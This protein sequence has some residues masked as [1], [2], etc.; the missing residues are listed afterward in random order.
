MSPHFFPSEKKSDPFTLLF[1]LRC[2]ATRMGEKKW[3]GDK[4]LLENPKRDQ[5]NTSHGEKENKNKKTHTNKI[6]INSQNCLIQIVKR[7]KIM[8]NS[9]FYYSILKKF[10][11]KMKKIL[12]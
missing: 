8:K 12:F 11:K 1:F 2:F 7:K 9:F 6:L 5:E 10:S 4:D 3:S